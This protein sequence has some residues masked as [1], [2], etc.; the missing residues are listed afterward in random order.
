M[1]HTILITGPNG[2]IG[3]V[4]IR[5]FDASLGLAV[6]DAENILTTDWDR[7][8][9]G[10]THVIHLAARTDI[11]QSHIRPG[12]FMDSN[13]RGLKMIA[14]ACLKKGVKLFFPSTTSTYG[15]HAKTVDETCTELKAY[16]PYAEAKLASERYLLGLKAQGLQF[17]ICRLGTIFGYSPGMRYTTAVNKFISEAIDRKPLSIWRTAWNQKRPY[18]Y[19]GDCI[20]AIHFILR[21]DFFDGEIYNVLTGNYTVEQVVS[22]IREYL[23]ALQT[24]LIDSP[25]MNPLS[26]EV[27][28]AKI[29]NL[30]FQPKGNLQTGIYE[31]IIKLK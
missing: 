26:Y 20:D 8:L 25:A 16:S 6:P 3:S 2:N 19:L 28:D 15:S 4:L 27:S 5:N 21:N 14:D 29:R 24:G 10:I 22:V 1:K 11:D 30:G 31:T 18:L 9:E 17:V 13:F 12:E 7:R 23:P